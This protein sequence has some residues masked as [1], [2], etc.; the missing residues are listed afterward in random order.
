VPPVA[1]DF[2]KELKFG[3]VEVEAKQV[4]FA[5]I[6]ITYAVCDGQYDLETLQQQ[7]LTAEPEPKSKKEN[8]QTEAPIMAAPRRR[9]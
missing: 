7:L 1:I 8:G 3:H 5:K 9:R 6:G 2:M 4:Y